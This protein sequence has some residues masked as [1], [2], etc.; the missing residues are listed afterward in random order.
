MLVFAC[1]SI[2]YNRIKKLSKHSS[3]F[4]MVRNLF[5]FKKND[6]HANVHI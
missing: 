2:N 6:I 3:G 5:T 1:D 4:F